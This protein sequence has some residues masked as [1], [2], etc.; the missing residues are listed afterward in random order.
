MD[1]IDGGS[2]SS[3]SGGSYKLYTTASS[4]S[5]LV[6]QC[7]ITA[8]LTGSTFEVIVVD[9]ETRNS[10][11]H[12]KLNPTGRYPLLETNDGTLAGVTAICKYLSRKAKKLYGSN[13][14]E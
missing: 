10:K 11:T 6:N 14:L 4:Y 5:N 8:E 9:D 12:Q 13:L 2:G 1:E 3:G 7:R